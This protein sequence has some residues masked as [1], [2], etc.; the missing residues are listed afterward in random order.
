MTEVAERA[1]A[2]RL[3]VA[4]LAGATITL[5]NVGAYGTASSAPILPLGQV[6]ILSTDGVRMSPVATRTG[7]DEWAVAVHPVGQLSL[8]FDHRVIDGAYAAAFLAQVRETLEQRDWSD[9]LRGLDD[10]G[11]SQE[12][13]R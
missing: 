2:G 13:D 6:A 1:R 7:G 11:R 12:V 8:S 5:T 4:E 9:E 3:T 10:P